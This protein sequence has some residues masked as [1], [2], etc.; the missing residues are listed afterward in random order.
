MSKLL[1]LIGFIWALPITLLAF[2]FYVGPL[3]ALGKYKQTGWNEVAF[4][5]RIEVNDN[6]WFDRILARLWRGWAGHALGNIVVLKS[7]A[8][9]KT[10]VH[11]KEHVK[12]MMKLGPLHLV[13]Y[14]LIYL[15]GRFVLSNVDG[16]RDNIFEIDARRKAEQKSE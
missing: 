12:Q 5:W 11:E 2:I 13:I 9:E 6:T 4:I 8:T 1:F 15:V 3:W 7:T 10:V 16:Y 14:G